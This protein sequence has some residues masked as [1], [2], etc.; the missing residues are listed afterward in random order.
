MRNFIA[1]NL[2]VCYPADR[3]LCMKGGKIVMQRYSVAIKA[4]SGI[5]AAMRK[6]CDECG[7]SVWK[8]L[9][10]TVVER[11][12]K[13]LGLSIAE[14]EQMQK[15]P[16][17]KNAEFEKFEFGISDAILQEK[18]RIIKED[19]GI[20]L[21]SFFVQTIAE[22]L[23][24]LGYDFDDKSLRNPVRKK[25]VKPK[26]ETNADSVSELRDAFIAIA[27]RKK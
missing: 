20:P 9:S 17:E 13:P 24:D 26:Q 4:D 25:A 15:R 27:M 2:C 1:E 5:S 7:I 19:Y 14:I 10:S 23:K 6:Y 11:L 21:S 12:R 22:K 16:Y 3:I 18:L 8:F